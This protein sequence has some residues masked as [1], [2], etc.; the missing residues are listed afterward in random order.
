MRFYFLLP[1]PR[2]RP[3]DPPP[4]GELGHAVPAPAVDLL[5]PLPLDVFRSALEALDGQR[6]GRVGGVRRGGR[7]VGGAQP[8]TA[9]MAPMARSEGRGERCLSR[10]SLRVFPPK[11]TAPM[12]TP[13]TKPSQTKKPTAS[14]WSTVVAPAKRMTW[15]RTKAMSRPP[16]KPT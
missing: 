1:A 8:H 3:H 16:T 7:R 15:A 5:V 10:N 13:A 2:P 12:V 11:V 9:R 4:P 6:V 14:P